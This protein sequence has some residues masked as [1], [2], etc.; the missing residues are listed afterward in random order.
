MDSPSPVPPK[1]RV[2]EASAWVKGRNSWTCASVAMPMPV[3]VTVIRIVARPSS[4]RASS[5]RMRTEP[6]GVNFTA[7]PA[8]LNSTCRMR[9]ES[10]MTSGG[11][12]GST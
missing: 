9:T 8:M 5:A 3:S 2:V 4:K 6:E 7:L 11:R 12:S 10:P 1:R